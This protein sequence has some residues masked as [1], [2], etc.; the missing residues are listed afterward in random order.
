MLLGNGGRQRLI[1]RRIVSAQHAMLLGNGRRQRLI[2]Q[3][4]LQRRVHLEELHTVD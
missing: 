2:V 4:S 3:P 1:G